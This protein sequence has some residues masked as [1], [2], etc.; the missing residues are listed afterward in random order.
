MPGATGQE[1]KQQCLGLNC[2]KGNCQFEPFLRNKNIQC[3]C[4]PR[5]IPEGRGIRQTHCCSC[6]KLLV[7]YKMDEH[8]NYIGGDL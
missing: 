5:D 3:G 2:E 6:K 7:I 1:C 8:Y 4:N